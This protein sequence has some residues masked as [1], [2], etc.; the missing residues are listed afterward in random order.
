MANKETS[1]MVSNKY[2]SIRRVRVLGEERGDE[3]ESVLEL[4]R[5]DGVPNGADAALRDATS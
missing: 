1:R 4:A 5:I 3:L 2:Q